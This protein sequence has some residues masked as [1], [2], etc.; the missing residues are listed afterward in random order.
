MHLPLGLPSHLPSLLPFLNNNTNYTPGGKEKKVMKVMN[1]KKSHKSAWYV[2]CFSLFSK[3]RRTSWSFTPQL[4]T[5]VIEVF[6]STSWQ[7]CTYDN[8]AGL[9]IMIFTASLKI[10]SLPKDSILWLLWP[11]ILL[12]EARCSFF[13]MTYLA[14]FFCR[15]WLSSTPR[16]ISSFGFSD[17]GWQPLVFHIVRLRV[18]SRERSRLQWGEW[19]GSHFKFYPHHVTPLLCS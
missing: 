10:T 1:V 18:R 15:S 3:P 7:G 8:V 5:V 2:Q 6:S 16:P 11:Q 4:D 19:R 14:F 12:A 17:Q 13:I 9:S